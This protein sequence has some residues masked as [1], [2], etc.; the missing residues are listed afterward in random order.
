[1][2]GFGIILLLATCN[3]E[4]AALYKCTGPKKAAVS[5]QSE[6]CPKG[7]IQIWVRDATPEPAP[8]AQQIR[9]REIKRQKDDASARELSQMAGTYQNVDTGMDSRHAQSD[10]NRVYCESVKKQAK[11]IRNRDWRTLTFEQLSRLDAWV[12]EACKNR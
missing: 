6:P 11:V 3:T 10:K 1:M 12:A 9:A 7:A 4:A 5:I 8:T 2:R